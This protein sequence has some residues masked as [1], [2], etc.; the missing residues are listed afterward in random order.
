MDGDRWRQRARPQELREPFPRPAPTIRAPIEPV[1]PAPLDLIQEASEALR[2]AGDPVV[3]VVP[4]QLPS[5]LA[6]LLAY[7]RMAVL[8]APPSDPGDRP[9]QAIGGRLLLDHPVP[10]PGFRPVVGEAQQI[11][12]SATR[13]VRWLV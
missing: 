9:T 2:V 7:W 6:M 5:E 1:A 13:G 11:E 10:T 3:P 12:R 4:P 8:A